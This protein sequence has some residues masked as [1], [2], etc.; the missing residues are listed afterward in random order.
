MRPAPSPR[1]SAA[2]MAA[3]SSSHARGQARIVSTTSVRI[4]ALT[5]RFGSFTAVDD[6]SVDIRAGEFFTL[7]GSSGCGKTTI[8]R[9]V[10]G[11]LGQSAGRV[12]FGDRPI[13]AVPPHRRNTGMVFQNYAIF[14]H[15]TVTQN[16]AYGLKARG[17]ARAE[18][19]RRVAR[20]LEMT[21]L[22]PFAARRPRELSGGQQQR[23]VL[24]RAVVIEP[25][26]LLMDEPLSNLDAEMR[27][28]LRNEIRAL[29]RE[30]GVTTIYVT[31]D[32]EEA[33]ALSDRIA[34]MRAGR[35]EQLGTPHEVF[36][37][38]RTR[39]VAGFIGESNMLDARRAGPADGA[40]RVPFETA[41]GLRLAVPTARIH[42]DGPRHVLAFRPHHVRIAADAPHRARL[43]DTLYSGTATRRMLALADGTGLVALS[44]SQPGV[45][46]EAPG[47]ELCFDI[48]PEAISAFAETGQ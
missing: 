28:H 11:F 6:V 42:G 34:V 45:F 32:Q 39:F 40:G 20:M 29:Q 25:D 16:I 33:L 37:A 23:V 44:L 30:I 26:V 10:A 17:M 13:D 5:K 22:A 12:L 38:P 18:I 48:A 8:L 36:N 2:A 47:T 7:L 27:V 19:D 14:P 35:I 9:I 41:G 24:A 3:L 21:R 31:H 43:T 1:A 4:E 15:L 46:A